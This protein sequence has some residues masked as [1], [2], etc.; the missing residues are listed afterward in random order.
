MRG[1]TTCVLALLAVVLMGCDA[2]GDEAVPGPAAPPEVAL[3]SPGTVS[4]ELPEFAVTFTPSGDTVFFN[5]TPADRSRIDLLFATRTESG[6]SEPQIFPPLEGVRAIDPFVSLDGAHLYFSSDLPREGGLSG[7]FN[8]WRLRLADADA[9]PEALASPINTDSSEVFNSL[10]ADGRMVFSSRRDGE[11][12]IYEAPSD[13]GPPVRLALGSGA[14]ASNPAIHPSGDYL[15]FSR[16][17]E[18]GGVDL[19]L[20]CREGTAWG[21]P[22]ILPEPVN[23][24]FTDFAPAFHGEHLFFTS[25]RPGVMGS[26]PDDQRPPGD[27]YRTRFDFAAALC[28]AEASAP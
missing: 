3:F 24:A 21:E 19:Y 28:G 2:P 5:R 15:V 7:S 6:W 18:D 16:A 8:L 12:W 1:A 27:L 9:T 11:R 17:G 13:G 23:S 4:S 26:V 25:E 10:S 14:P 20:S 22:V